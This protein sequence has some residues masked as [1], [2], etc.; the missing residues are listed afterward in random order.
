MKLVVFA[1]S[2]LGYD[3]LNVLLAEGEKIS[4]VFTHQ[5]SPNESI[6]F[7][8]VEQL[9]RK[10]Q[11][12]VF[13]CLSPNTPETIKMI[14]TLNP[15]IIF[16]FY[17]RQMIC[18]EI[19]DIPTLGSFNM[20]GS[21]LPYYRGRCPVNWAIIHGESKTGATLHYMVKA[22]DAG[23]IVDQEQVEI[24]I[25]DTAGVLMNKINNAAQ[26]ILKRQLTLLKRGRA[27]RIAQDHSK[28]SYFG[29]RGPKDGKI[30]W[31]QSALQIHNLIRALQPYPQYP[32]AFTTLEEKEVWVMKSIVP[33]G[34]MTFPST[35]GQIISLDQT[36]IEVACGQEGSERLKIEKVHFK[37]RLDGDARLSLEVGQ[38]F[39]KS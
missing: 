1:Y 37:D 19:L 8:S 24:K 20:H 26:R 7:E 17:Y 35:P 29:G 33:T 28:A 14:Q 18:Q 36:G 30:N 39:E 5:N 27:P 23:D 38:I 31:C 32:P 3:C 21:L 25:T 6:W 15:D 13:T 16:S 22:A 2:Q 12:P 11:I 34:E 10:N 9:A 4:A